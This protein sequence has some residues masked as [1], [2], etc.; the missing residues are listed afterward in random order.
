MTND[1]IMEEIRGQ[2]ARRKRRT[3]ESVD[4][5][6]ELIRGLGLDSLD[7]AAVV[8]GVEAQMGGELDEGAVDWVS[9]KTVRDLAGA[10]KKHV[11]V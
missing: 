10:L 1:Q 11:K 8:V 4:A 7:Y 9:V 5:D 3:I 6:A 2:I